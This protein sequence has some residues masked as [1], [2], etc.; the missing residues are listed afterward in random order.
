MCC[1]F[2][3]ISSWVK[4]LC[5]EITLRYCLSI[6]KVLPTNTTPGCIAKCE[7]IK[8]DSFY[9]SGQC[10]GKRQ[11]ARRHSPAAYSCC[12]LNRTH[13]A[14]KAET[15]WG[16]R[17]LCVC[18]WAWISGHILNAVSSLSDLGIHGQG[19]QPATLSL[20]PAERKGCESRFK[21]WKSIQWL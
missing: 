10:G 11:I 17:G 14:R 8:R 16:E 15:L 2:S 13:W 9:K 20:A 3:E 7:D 1:H 6:C 18:V 21:V 5:V 4:M 12:L 19:L